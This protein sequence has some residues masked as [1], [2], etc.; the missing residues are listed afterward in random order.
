MLIEPKNGQIQE[1]V[2]GPSG[3]RFSKIQRLASV[4]LVIALLA[5]SVKVFQLTTKPEATLRSIADS[6]DATGNAFFT[7][8]E[9][10]ILAINF[11]RWL[12]GNETKRAVLIRR[13]L[14]GQ[15]LNVKDSAGV[16]N[17]ERASS[18]YLK[19][20][21]EI[22]ICLAEEGEGV[23]LEPRQTFVRNTCG[24]SLEVL[25]FE[26]RQ[27]GIEISNAGDVRL[28]EIIRRDRDDRDTQ[29]IQLLSIVTF[30][31][32]VGGLLGVSRT[33]A[34]QRV[35][36]VIESDE[37]KLK[38]A[39]D[40]LALLETQVEERIKSDK[41]Q[42]TEDQRLDAEL[43]LLVTGLRNATSSAIAIAAF[44]NGIHRLIDSEYIYAQFFAGVEE[45][46]LAYSLRGDAASVIDLEQLGIDRDFRSDLVTVS[47]QILNENVAGPVSMAEISKLVSLK[48]ISDFKKLGL[49]DAS[50]FVP[51]SEGQVVLGCVIFRKGHPA[52]L[53]PNQHAAVQ[54]AVAQAANSIGALR[55]MS[56]VQKVRENEQVVSE[57]RALDRLKDEFTAN[58]NHELRTPLTSI[59]GYLELVMSDS[60]HLPETTLSYLA[61]VRR[62]ADRLTELIERLLV[63]AKSDNANADFSGGKVDFAQVVRN[64]VQIVGQKDPAKSIDIKTEIDQADFSMIGD[65]LRLEQIV[66]NL[67]SNAIKFSKGYSTVF[68]T[69]RRLPSE[70]GGACEAELTI[71]DTGIGI[72]ANEIPHLFNRF[73][74]ASN[75]TKALIPGTGLGMSIVKQ[76]VEDHKGQ[77]S[78]KS[79]VSH[80]TTVHV[81][82]P[83]APINS[84]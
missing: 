71:R 78:I 29:I 76:F 18:A 16:T 2:I 66:I 32:V 73:F 45:Q 22:D 68:V 5:L 38:V 23:L 39:R 7:Q 9:T 17:A 62:N 57:L 72:P 81:R 69:L 37:E 28:R 40:S 3:L 11:E 35:R 24:G 25:T 1:S 27:L 60:Q 70:P 20:L 21:Q 54:S 30:I 55:S 63:V 19:A 51:I 50:V 43:R 34:L 74:R 48:T 53:P 44:V 79:V 56:L 41:I 13:S 31:L 46:D 42:R 14:L 33:R 8:R 12:S 83:L 4:F 49:D 61:T 10:L 80:G 65:Q 59:I 26:A 58:V 84:V 67:V 47:Q 15:R 77:I 75:A 52:K 6:D 36:R 64:A 82:L